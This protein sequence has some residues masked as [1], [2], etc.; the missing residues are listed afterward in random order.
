MNG[1]KVQTTLRFVGDW[2]WWLGLGAALLLGAGACVL[3]RRDVRTLSTW[4]R[5]LLPGLRGVAIAMIVLMLSG[6]VL[7]HRKVV[8]ELSAL[9]LFVDGS[10]SM[11]LTDPSMSAA[12]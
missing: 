3:Y 1:E 9:R 4:L 10:Q 6:P 11:Q 8:G 12:R 5:L 2:P 7:H